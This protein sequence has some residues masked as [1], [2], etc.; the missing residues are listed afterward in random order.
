M[1]RIRLLSSPWLGQSQSGGPRPTEPR[2]ARRI[3]C[4]DAELE[5]VLSEPADPLRV[6][7]TRRALR[8]ASLP[9]RSGRVFLRSLCFA[10][11]ESSEVVCES[12]GLRGH[13][14]GTSCNLRPNVEQWRRTH[15]GPSRGIGFSSPLPRA[16]AADPQGLKRPAPALHRDHRERLKDLRPPQVRRCP[17]VWVDRGVVTSEFAELEREREDGL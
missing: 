14:R 15:H 1:R 16:Y 7:P 13:P 17:N 5:R 2:L 9:T 11:A 12:T 10:I 8:V 3:D 4:R 6:A